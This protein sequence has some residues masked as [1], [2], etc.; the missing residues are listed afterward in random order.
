MRAGAGVAAGGRFWC[1][2]VRRSCLQPTGGNQPF[3]SAACPTAAA[4]SAAVARLKISTCTPGRSRFNG[5]ELFH[6]TRP[7]DSSRTRVSLDF[8]VVPGP[9]YDDDY[10]GSRSPKNGRQS[11]F[12][13]GYYAWAECGKDGVW[14][15]R[16]DGGGLVRGNSGSARST[17]A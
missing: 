10:T 15:V 7:N 8:R 11:F 1:S 13:G 9:L 2:A 16:D 17:S 6:F 14:S 4:C 3:G 5:N 12:L